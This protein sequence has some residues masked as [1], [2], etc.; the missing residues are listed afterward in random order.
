[1]TKTLWLTMRCRRVSDG[2]GVGGRRKLLPPCGLCAMRVLPASCE[3]HHHARMAWRWRNE[4]IRLTGRS[5]LSLGTGGGEEASAQR[6]LAFVCM[7]WYMKMMAMTTNI[8]P[9]K[10]LKAEEARR[11]ANL[12]KYISNARQGGIGRGEL[13]ITPTVRNHGR[14]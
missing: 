4:H 12:M 9:Q 10:A 11:P 8:R 13:R 2:G 7:H 5:L 6:W 14:W 1:M 3:Y